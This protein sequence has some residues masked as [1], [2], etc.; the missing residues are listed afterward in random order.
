VNR[1][2]LTKISFIR[3]KYLMATNG[4]YEV[5]SPWAEADPVPLKGLT[6][7]VSDLKGKKIGLLGNT[8]RATKPILTVVEK[9]LRERFPDSVISSYT[10]LNAIGPNEIETENK[11]KFEEW[12]KGVDAVVAAVGD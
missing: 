12:L 9:K 6:A 4:E 10:T 3:R 5:L 7:R 2:I 1:N 8:K 11:A